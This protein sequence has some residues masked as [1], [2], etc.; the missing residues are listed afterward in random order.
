[1][2]SV[3]SWERAWSQEELCSAST[4]WSL[5]ADA[6][7][8]FYLQNFSSDLMKKTKNLEEQVDG[9]VFATKATEIRLNNAFNKFLMLSNQQYIENRVYDDDM[10]ADSATELQQSATG[11]E[12]LTHE[13]LEAILIPKYTIAITIGTE[14]TMNLANID[15][16]ED[17]ENGERKEINPFAV[18]PLPF[19]IGT[20]AFQEDEFAGILIEDKEEEVVESD[21]PEDEIVED[22]DSESED[23]PIGIQ[24]NSNYTSRTILSADP[25]LSSDSDKEGNEVPSQSSAQRRRPIIPEDDEIIE[26]DD[27]EEEPTPQRPKLVIEEANENSKQ[28]K[29][30]KAEL[31]SL[32]GSPDPKSQ[33][34]EAVSPLTDSLEEGKQEAKEKLLWIDD[35][36]DWEIENAKSQNSQSKNNPPKS[37]TPTPV[38]VKEEKV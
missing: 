7:L 34:Q 32:F 4:R 28:P 10:I 27:D 35:E 26:E 21:S 19:V 3:K 1:M 16:E 22:Y 24:Q 12:Q 11:N 15:V 33:K 2:S 38:T 13:Q 36:N 20:R 31:A 18:D 6:G 9:L 14:A 29:D 25:F 23:E 17:E 8:L 5:A 37:Q 30:F